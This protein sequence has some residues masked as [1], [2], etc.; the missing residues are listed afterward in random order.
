MINQQMAVL[1][2][3]PLPRY[4]LYDGQRVAGQIQMAVAVRN[5]AGRA[6]DGEPNEPVHVDVILFG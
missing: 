1:T 4:R 6:D 5:G 3:H 2:H